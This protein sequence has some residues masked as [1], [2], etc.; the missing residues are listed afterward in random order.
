[1]S[2]KTLNE[3][4]KIIDIKLIS[5]IGFLITIL[6]SF[7]LT[8]DQKLTL[9]KKTNIFSEKETQEISFLQS[10]LV[11]INSFCFLYANI[12]EYTLYKDEKNV[13]KED[14]QLQTFTSILAI[15]S[16]IIGL[17]IV[18]KQNNDD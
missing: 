10:I 9:I 12:K 13:N 18:F 6:I 2:N 1:M 7:F 3:Q 16:A 15:I 5:T 11:F 14:L 17:Y 8:I 4:I